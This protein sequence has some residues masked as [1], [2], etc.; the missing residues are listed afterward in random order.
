MNLNLKLDLHE[1]EGLVARG[2]IAE[3]MAVFHSA[4]NAGSVQAALQLGRC[5]LHFGE[6]DAQRA[7][8]L[9]WIRAAAD[10]GLAGA[11]AELAALQLGGVLVQ[12]DSIEISELLLR[13]AQSPGSSADRAIAALLLDAS[14]P[15]WHDQGA[16]RMARCAEAGD[17]LARAL[18]SAPHRL[19]N[20]R[21]KDDIRAETL[22]ELIVQALTP[23]SGLILS[24]EPRVQ[25]RDK[26]LS[27]FA[28]AY[29]RASAMPHLRPSR[30]LDPTRGDA[31]ADA[32]RS[33]SDCAFDP[34]QEDVFLRLLQARM[35]ALAGVPPACAEHL[36]VLRYRPGEEYK[37]HRDYL[38]HVALA[39]HRP[40]AGQRQ[41]TIC[42]YLNEV[43]A[44]GET[45]FPLL[46]LRVRP[47]TGRAVVFDNV[48]YEQDLATDVPD[49]R[50]L[51]AGLPVIQ[52]E[53]WLATLWLRQRRY[54]YC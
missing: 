44:G 40:Q 11:C 19:A 28:C 26:L 3:A 51:H 25:T 8:A 18:V 54:R 4:A 38:T 9:P 53:K 6:A 30:V 37:P 41:R 50:S 17:G 31:M 24:T 34:L 10:H 33:S 39:Q 12:G 2:Q 5:L 20:Q 46:D 27:T 15:R 49:Q 45:A 23:D 1:A 16:V 22:S 47:A 42:V 13:G 52:G 14:D 35:A 36:V 32:L 48:L 29:V 7:M 43:E 21:T